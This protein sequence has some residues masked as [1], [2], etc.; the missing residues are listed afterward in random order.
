MSFDMLEHVAHRAIMMEGLVDHLAP[1]GVLLLST[2]CGTSEPVL[3]PEWVHHRIEYSAASLY[4]FLRRY[5]G[6]I[7]RPEDSEFP[8]REVVDLLAEGPV[9]YLLYMNPIVC[10]APIRIENPYR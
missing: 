10:R 4:D 2:P 9:S 3:K 5:F 8:H 1:H 7:V 6:E